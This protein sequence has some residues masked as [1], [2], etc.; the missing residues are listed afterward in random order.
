M[1]IKCLN[2]FKP[3]LTKKKRV[4]I[5]VGGRSSTKSTFTADRVSCGMAQGE[6]WACGREFQNS[7]DES[8]HRLLADEIGRLE[9]KGFDIRAKDIIHSNGGRSFYIGLARNVLSLKGKLSGIHGLWIEEGEGLSDETLRVATAS[10]RATAAEYDAA[11]KAGIELHEPEIWITMNRRSRQDPIAKRYL[12]RAEPSLARKGFYEDDEVMVVEANYTD[13]PKA[14]FLASGLETERASDKERMSSKEYN[15]KWHGQYM[16]AIENSI[17][18]EEWFDACID[19]HKELGFKPEGAEVLAHDPSDEGEDAKGLAHLW[20][21]VFVNV[22]EKDTGNVNQ[23]CDWALE[24]ALKEKVDHFVWD[25]VGLGSGLKQQISTAFDGKKITYEGFNGGETPHNPGDM[26]DDKKTNREF[27]FNR[28]AQFYRLLADS[29]YNTYKARQT[30]LRHDPEDLISFSSDMGDKVID[31]LRSE[32]C[33]IPAIP[34]KTK[35]QILGKQSMKSKY[36]V[37][38]P[39]L[40]DSVMMALYYNPLDHGSWDEE[41]DYPDEFMP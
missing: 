38:S 30:S 18:K 32:L 10:V 1:Q 8:V 2:K 20:G 29:M 14:W 6:L 34:D 21:R 33:R 12:A 17:I 24:Y 41:L 25:N 7:I 26:Y 15:H 40:A 28:R 23:G 27:F 35:F 16:E 5:I 19:A 31:K 22:L 11:K 37:P 39:N 13:M 36:N 9:I 3:L 4:K